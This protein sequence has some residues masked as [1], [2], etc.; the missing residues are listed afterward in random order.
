[1]NTNFRNR[2]LKPNPAKNEK[3][4]FHFNNRQAIDKLE[5]EFD[6]IRVKHN[7]FLKYLGITLDCALTFNEHPSSLSK[8][9]RSR[10]NSVQMMAGMG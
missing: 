6:G 8:K 2:G 4:S 3:K 7:F 10:T 1:M 9:I 5:V